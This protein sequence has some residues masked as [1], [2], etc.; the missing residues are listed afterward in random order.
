MTSPTPPPAPPTPEE[1]AAAEHAR[2][3]ALNRAS[4]VTLSNIA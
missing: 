2:I 4:I 3:I 1:L